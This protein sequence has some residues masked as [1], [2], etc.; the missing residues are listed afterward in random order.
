MSSVTVE[1]PDEVDEELEEFL[2]R[3]PHF[4]DAEDLMLAFIRGVLEMEEATNN[5]EYA[6]DMVERDETEEAVRALRN[7]ISANQEAEEALLET[8][9]VPMT[10]STDAQEKVQ[11]SEREF[12]NG[13]YVALEDV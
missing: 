10:L 7:A 11:R 6:A 12:E 3:N 2:E 4:T 1:I 9:G 8:F 5:V 13:D